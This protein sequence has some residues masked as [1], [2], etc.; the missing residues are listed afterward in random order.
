MLNEPG[1]IRTDY[2]ETYCRVRRSTS[3]R[4][5]QLTTRL[6]K[7]RTR[8]AARPAKRPTA[9]ES[10]EVRAARR[11]GGPEDR[12]LYSCICGFVFE[13]PVTTSVGCPHCGTEQAW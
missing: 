10:P 7:R 8:R 3:G 5:M 13:A 1:G 12:A 11:A 4:F 9:Y 2:G 6:P